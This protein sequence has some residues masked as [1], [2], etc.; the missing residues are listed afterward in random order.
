M[1]S[2]LDS[3][4]DILPAD[5]VKV[6]APPK[7][8][9]EAPIS[10]NGVAISADDIRAEAQ[11]HPAK[12]PGEALGEAARALVVR[13]LLV[14]A[15]AA[16]GLSGEPEMLSPGKRETQEDAAIRALLENEVVTPSANEANCLRYY[17]G[18]LAKFRSETIF[19]ARHILFAAPKSDE[20]ARSHAHG[21]A[22]AAIAVLIDN[23]LQFEALAQM[24]SACPSK[25]QGGNLGQLTKGSTVPEFE[26]VLFELSEGQLSPTPVATPFGYHV[27]ELVRIIEG[28][29]LPFEMVRERIA[30]WLEA[31]SWS[32]AVSQYIGILSGEAKICGIDLA[33]ADSP[34]VQ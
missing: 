11:L 6:P 3:Y 28:K 1:V 17:E 24:Y 27:I 30:A 12:N 34:L 16:R 9:A 14:Q 21:D 8:P 7:A 10:V 29:Q 18:N 22:E 31:S 15:A 2:I 32:R 23:P 5:K 19:E 4:S 20:A 26:A 13:E 25:E 33:A